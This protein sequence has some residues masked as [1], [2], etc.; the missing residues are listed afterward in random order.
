MNNARNVHTVQIL[1]WKPKAE[2]QAGRK[3]CLGTCGDILRLAATL[4]P[5]LLGS[6]LSSVTGC[7]RVCCHLSALLY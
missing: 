5:A 1:S 4:Y 6:S 7:G 2:E 3:V